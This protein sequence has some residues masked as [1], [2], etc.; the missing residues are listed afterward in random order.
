MH[1]PDGVLSGPVLAAT[2][3][4]SAAGVAVGLRKMNY[5][6]VPRVGVLASVFFVASLIRVPVGV[7]SAHLLL[8]GLLGFL[9]GWAVF[10]AMTAALLL[11]AILFGFGGVTPLGANVFNMAA[12]A[13]LCYYLFSR[14]VGPGTP[15]GRVFGLAFAAGAIGVVLSCVLNVVALFASGKGFAGP[16][17]AILLG[18]IPVV[19][20]EGFVS[21]FIVSFL[22]KVRPELLEKP[23][24]D[25]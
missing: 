8:I 17:G 9:L 5:E 21:A 15:Q 25:S 1:I 20:V 4:L 12:P 22:H 6:Q 2:T 18:H 23:L 19:A 11:Q 24:V 13:L 10:P 7:S 3:V 16:A 14:R